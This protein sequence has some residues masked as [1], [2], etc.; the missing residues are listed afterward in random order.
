M[1]WEQRFGALIELDGDEW[2]AVHKRLEQ[3]WLAAYTA[4]FVEIAVSRGWRLEDAATWPTTPRHY[5]CLTPATRR[6]EAGLATRHSAKPTATTGTHGGRL[7]KTLSLAKSHPDCPNRGS[8][9]RTFP[10]GSKSPEIS[11]E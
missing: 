9:Q 8:P 6:A 5:G 4:A 11:S 2:D 10:H 3:E 1:A 7:W